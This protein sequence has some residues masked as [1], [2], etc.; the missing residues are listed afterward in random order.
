MIV[1]LD[2]A[3][4]HLRADS[5][6]DDDSLIT[7][8]IGAAENQIRNFINQEIPGSGYSP[9]EIPDDIK[10]AALLIIGGLYEN[11]EDKIIGTIV[12]DNPAVMNLLYPHRVNIGI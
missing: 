10:A 11:R 5:S 9:A 6:G 3:K 7:L 8:Y 1:T 4:K 12:A 2:E